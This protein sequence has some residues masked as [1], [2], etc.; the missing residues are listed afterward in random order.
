[1]FVAV[2]LR[3]VFFAVSWEIARTLKWLPPECTRSAG[4]RPAR[5]RLRSARRKAPTFGNLRSQPLTGAL[6]ERATHIFAM[7]GAHV[8]A[9]QM[10]FPHGADKTFLLR[11]FEEPGTTCWRDV[12]DPIGLGRDVYTVCAATIKNALPSVLAFV[13]QSELACGPAGAAAALPSISM[14]DISYIPSSPLAVRNLNRARRRSAQGRSGDLRCGCGRRKTAARKYRAD[15]VGKFHQPRRDGG[16]GQRPD[17]QIRRRLSGKTLVRRLRKCRY[18]RITR[19]RSRQ[20]LVRRR[21]RQRA[22][23][24]RRAG[25]H[26]GLFLDAK[27]GRQDSDHESR[28]WRSSHPRA[29]GEFFRQILSSHPLRRERENRAD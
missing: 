22:T 27:A 11:E 13:E 20:A 15:R 6:V 1:M 16:A 19:D 18:R 26:G 5:T 23:T 17:Q 29:S 2:P 12:P 21:T 25:E 28:P 8:E 4:S 9:I 10:L 24:Q 3:K 14:S 7:T